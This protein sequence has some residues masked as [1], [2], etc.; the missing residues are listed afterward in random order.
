MHIYFRAP[1]PNRFTSGGNIFNRQL[2][3][4]LSVL[5]LSVEFQSDEQPI[6]NGQVTLW[7]SLLLSSLIQGKHT[8]KSG[9]HALLV[10]SDTPLF[11]QQVDRLRKQGI[12]LIVPGRSLFDQ[13]L[14]GGFPRESCLLLEPGGDSTFPPNAASPDPP[15]NLA[16]VA[17]LTRD[18]GIDSFLRQWPK[19]LPVSPQALKIHLYGD[20]RIDPAHAREILDRCLRPEWRQVIIYHGIVPQEQLFV[21][22]TDY[23]GLLSVSP[24]ESF[25]MA[26]RDARQAGLPVLA[27]R[28]GNIPNVILDGTDGKLYPHL[29][30]LILDLAERSRHPAHFFSWLQAFTPRKLEVPSWMEQ[31][32]KLATWW[33]LRLQ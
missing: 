20:D 10:H 3:K 26:I 17:N 1:D 31:A 14:Q 25:G 7:D 5:G 8:T 4:A 11:R 30:E 15:V 18:K 2:A 21:E 22:W 16:I 28:G 24:A 32:E 23:H 13:L 33:R 27:L 19:H 29:Q 9:V 12:S 6:K